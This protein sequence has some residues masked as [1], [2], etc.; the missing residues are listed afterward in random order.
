MEMTNGRWLAVVTVLSA[1]FLTIWLL[2]NIHG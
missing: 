2:K 1:L